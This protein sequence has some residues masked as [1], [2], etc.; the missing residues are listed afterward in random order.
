MWISVIAIAICMPLT[1]AQFKEDQAYVS[2]SY[3]AIVDFG[4]SPSEL[5]LDSGS[6]QILIQTHAI[7][8]TA[9]IESIEAV[10][11]S[12]SQNQ[13]VAVIMNS[14]NL[15]SGDSMNGNY[16]TDLTFSPFSQVGTWT[17]KH[18]IVCNS[19]GEC[20]RINATTAEMLGFPAELQVIKK[21]ENESTTS[22]QG[23][24]ERA[25]YLG[26]DTDELR[27]WASTEKRFLAQRKIIINNVFNRPSNCWP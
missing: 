14:T 20:R 24:K 13:S 11:F 10:F 7:D 3:P 25:L 26:L 8:E 4:F 16:S 2:T 9:G 22:L 12:P 18:L 1:A 5:I 21:A 17:L 19:G 15:L 23:S 27:G 6:S